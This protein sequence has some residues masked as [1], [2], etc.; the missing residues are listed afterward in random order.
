[1]E[2]KCEYCGKLSD[3]ATGKTSIPI[4]A[5]LCKKCVDRMLIVQINSLTHVIKELLAFQKELAKKNSGWMDK[6]FGW[7]KKTE[8]DTN[9]G[10]EWKQK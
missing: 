8:E 1:M 4:D 2:E 5:N 9:E 7:I 6:M 3:W 10:E